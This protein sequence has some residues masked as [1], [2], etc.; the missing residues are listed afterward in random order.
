VLKCAELLG[1][2]V[3]VDVWCSMV[4]ERVKSN[5]SAVSLSVLASVI[6]GSHPDQLCPRL[7]D[8]A[9]A[10]SDP[11]VCQLAEVLLLSLLSLLFLPSVDMFTR[12][13]K[14]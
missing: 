7:T 3:R 11:G 8:I 1:Y 12:E 5:Q 2:F 14:F 6:R 4:L 9:A 13:F 10:I